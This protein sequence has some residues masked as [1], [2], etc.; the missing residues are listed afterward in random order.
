MTKGPLWGTCM[1]CMLTIRHELCGLLCF[2]KAER[3]HVEIGAGTWTESE[4]RRGGLA[5]WPGSF[6]DTR[7]SSGAD[8]PSALCFVEGGLS[9]DW[10][11]G[12]CGF[13]SLDLED[14]QLLLLW[15]WPSQ[16]AETLRHLRF[17]SLQLCFPMTY[18]VPQWGR[19]KCDGFR[20]SKD[21]SR[22]ALQRG[23]CVHEPSSTYWNLFPLNR[24]IILFHSQQ[25]FFLFL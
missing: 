7:Q 8:F 15:F 17:G 18:F 9:W 24:V 19:I 2:W 22:S 6:L 14:F 1:S 23:G 10:A 4:M 5:K 20:I 21:C 13:R 12:A 3:A 16:P 11:S 25:L